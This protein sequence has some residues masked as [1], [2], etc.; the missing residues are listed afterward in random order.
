MGSP[1]QGKEGPGTRQRDV[2]HSEVGESV[3]FLGQFSQRSHL[4]PIRHR[5][6]TNRVTLAL[7]PFFHDTS[8]NTDLR[9]PQAAL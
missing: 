2:L 4:I 8:N 7:Y 9:L 5:I 1:Q 6:L 3:H